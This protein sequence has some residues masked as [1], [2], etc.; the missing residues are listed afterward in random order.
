MEAASFFYSDLC[1]EDLPHFPFE[2]G[3]VLQLLESEIKNGN[4][5]PGCG[6]GREMGSAGAIVENRKDRVPNCELSLRISSLGLCW[7]LQLL[8]CA[9]GQ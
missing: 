1:S 3:F 5:S 6:E 8:Q 2:A 7:L 4:G 9:C